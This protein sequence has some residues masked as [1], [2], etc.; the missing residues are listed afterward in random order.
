[1]NRPAAR[2]PGARGSCR[3]GA[4]GRRRRERL[5]DACA[6][7][8]DLTISPSPDRSRAAWSSATPTAGSSPRSPSTRVLV[9]GATRSGKTT[10]YAIPALL[11]WDGPAIVL[12]AKSDLLHAT[13]LDRAGATATC[14]STTPPASPATRATAGPR[15]AGPA[16]G[17]APSAPPTR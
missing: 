3:R 7:R 2:R 10:G 11:E 4:R 5:S 8:R 13:L 1:M 6:T 12:S 14:G 17:P 9:V 16:T 15:C